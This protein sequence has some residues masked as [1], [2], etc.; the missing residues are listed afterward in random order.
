MAPTKAT[1]AAAP[2]TPP[3]H[4]RELMSGFPTGVG[5]VTAFRADGRPMGMTCS[6]ICSV[7]L[8][9]PVLLVALRSAS[10]TLAAVLDGSAFSLNLLH[11]GAREVAKLF[12]SGD[13]DRFD[14][15]DWR[16]GSVGGGPHLADAAHAMADCR[17][18]RHE[19][20]GDHTVVYGEV[21]ATVTA[22]GAA[23]PLLYGQ[24]RYASWPAA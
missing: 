18:T 16:R 4:F 3:D 2:C 1:L 17:V 20:V 21:V 24:R 23:R 19:A 12:A 10:P 14:R 11:E 9:P 13:A 15:V 5:V 6:S 7:S 22:P 8:E